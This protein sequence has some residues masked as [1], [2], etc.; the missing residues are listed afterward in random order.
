MKNLDADVLHASLDS[1][2][3]VTGSQL[4]SILWSCGTVTE[5]THEATES[6]WPAVS[7]SHRESPSLF[8]SPSLSSKKSPGSCQSSI[9]LPS[10]HNCICFCPAVMGAGSNEFHDPKPQGGKHSL[11]RSPRAGAAP[12]TAP[13][14]QALPFHTGVPKDSNES[15]FLAPGDLQG[16]A[17]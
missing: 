9:D 8:F 11:K 17:V 7:L 14:C 2:K 15:V 12:R 13:S 3:E 1:Q 10:P 5:L 4:H 16:Q 6:Y